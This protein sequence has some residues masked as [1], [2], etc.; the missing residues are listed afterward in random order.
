MTYT[1][2]QIADLMTRFD[3]EVKAGTARVERGTTRA[4]VPAVPARPGAFVVEAFARECG[5][6]VAAVEVEAISHGPAVLAAIEQARL[7]SVPHFAGYISLWAYRVTDSDGV[8]V[9]GATPAMR[10]ALDKAR[11]EASNARVLQS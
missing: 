2:Q 1:E 8:S 9:D 10:D 4:I 11:I 3:S 5:T 7:A 6:T